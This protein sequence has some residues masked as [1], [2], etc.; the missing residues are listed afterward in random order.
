MKISK[1]KLD[2]SLAVA[3]TPLRD[4]IVANSVNPELAKKCMAEVLQLATRANSRPF[5]FGSI[6]ALPGN[7]MLQAYSLATSKK[8]TRLSPILVSNSSPKNVRQLKKILKKVHRSSLGKGIFGNFWWR[9]HD[10]HGVQFPAG[11]LDHFT[12]GIGGRILATVGKNL[13]ADLD[14]VLWARL[15]VSLAT[16]LRVSL[17]YFLRLALV[18][19]VERAGRFDPLMRQLS[20]GYFPLATMPD[21]PKKLIVLVA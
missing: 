4:Y 16:S 11:L 18:G 14:K 20:E 15:V 10:S 7:E 9:I 6:E 13:V 1:V 8:V 19:D 2:K 3:F 12:A 21:D 17:Y 5:Q